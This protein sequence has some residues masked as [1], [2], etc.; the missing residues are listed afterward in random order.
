MFFIN[1]PGPGELQGNYRQVL[2]EAVSRHNILPLTSSCNLCCSFCS[3]RHMPPGLDVF[4]FPPLPEDDLRELIPFLDGRSKIVIG[5]SATRLCEGE[6]FTH[7][8][9]LSVLRALRAHFPQTPLQLTTNGTLL[10][11]E[12][13]LA[14]SKSGGNNEQGEPLLEL[15]ISFNCSEPVLRRKVLGDEDP[16]Q[17]LRALECCR[18]H[19]IPFQGSV[20]AVP[21]LTGWHELE[22]TLNFLDAAGA[23]MIR[24]FLPGATRFASSGHEVDDLLWRD[25]AILRQRLQDELDCPV[26]LEPPL[27]QDLLARVEGV[28]KDTPAQQAGLRSGDVICAVN[29]KKVCSSVDAFN[30]IR[31]SSEPLLTVER[32]KRTMHLKLL[33][34]G[35]GTSPGFVMARDLAT[36]DMHAVQNEMDRCRAVTPLL[37]TS[38]AA[39]PLWQAALADNLIPPQIRIGVVPNC[40][41]GGTICCAGLLTVSDMHGYL[42]KLAE[43]EKPDLILLPGAPFDSRGR[44]LRGE[45]YQ[46]LFQKFPELNIKLLNG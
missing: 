36:A 8:A 27:K 17:V 38:R 26:L 2:L 11:D 46:E 31:N 28:M 3:H 12:T 23:R 7:P 34:K 29:G 40:F 1:N 4:T 35:K 33:H 32:L 41:F 22:K 18:T 44:D 42:Q 9:V 25:L 19:G 45:S 10:D 43:I 14:L 6:P 30:L 21:Q 37:L 24:L 13:V 16:Q 20:V 15:I 39:A 5:E